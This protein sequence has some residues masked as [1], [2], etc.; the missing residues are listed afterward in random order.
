MYFDAIWRLQ[1]REKDWEYDGE[2][3]E[4]VTAMTE[5]KETIG[6]CEILEW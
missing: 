2:K 6:F 1:E 4:T 5:S 3:Q